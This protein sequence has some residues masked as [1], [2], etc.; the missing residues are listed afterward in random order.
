M[1]K[2]GG[3]VRTLG[4]SKLQQNYVIFMVQFEDVLGGIK[5]K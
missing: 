4:V 1:Y 5:T 3:C 2:H